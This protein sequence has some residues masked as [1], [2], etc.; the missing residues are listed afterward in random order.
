MEFVDVINFVIWLLPTLVFLTQA[1]I[2]IALLHIL[3]Y[4]KGFLYNAYAE[5]KD[6]L[7]WM[8]FA[9]ALVSTVGSLFFSEVLAWDP[10]KLCWYERIFMYP[11]V[12]ILGIA[13]WKNDRRVADY[14]LLLIALGSLIAIYHYGTQLASKF[15]AIEIGCGLKNISCDYVYLFYYDY[16][17]IPMMALTGFAAIGM[18]VYLGRKKS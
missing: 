17:T 16:I 6:K 12:I 15:Y 3:F 2:V 8:A 11:L 13:A 4:R 9:V 5:N 18:L 14:S 1:G 7:L 10:C